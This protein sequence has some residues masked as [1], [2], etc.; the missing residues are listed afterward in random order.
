[1]FS[2][3]NERKA[4]ISKFVEDYLSIKSKELS[5]INTWGKDVP[6]RVNSF[7]KDGKMIRGALVLFAHDMCGK[8]NPEYALRCAAAIEILQ[9]YLLIHDDI[10]DRDKF[11]RGNPSI[12]HQYSLM[13]PEIPA[14]QAE[15]FGSSMGICAGDVSIF[16]AL[17]LILDNNPGSNELKS[18]MKLFFQEMVFVGLGQMQDIYFGASMKIPD[19]KDVIDLYTYKTSRYTFSLPLKAGALISGDS[20]NAEILFN[21]GIKLG[22][23]FQI[24]DDELGL[25]G[26]S[27]KIG[28]VAGSDVREGKMT[29]FMTELFPLLSSVEKEKLY[30]F[31]GKES[32]G[33]DD[34]VYLRNIIEDKQ[35]R[36]KVEKIKKKLSNECS[37]LVESLNAAEEQK[38]MIYKLLEYNL[39]REK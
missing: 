18:I 14:D 15:H 34:I 24:R 13:L 28:K 7:T 26:E 39:T 12:F 10:M 17:D 22:I 31:F 20:V 3:I 9:S 2:Y 29:I 38:N 6:E 16:L 32:A 36:D 23:I 27:D 35:V 25:F 33:N 19:S 8:R 4:L 11:R 21:I 1:M 37:D 30:T 5:A